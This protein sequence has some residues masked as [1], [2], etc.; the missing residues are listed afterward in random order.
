[1]L[2]ATM[3][4]QRAGL[5][6]VGAQLHGALGDVG[7]EQQLS[8]RLWKAGSLQGVRQDLRKSHAF[9]KMISPLGGTAGQS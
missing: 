3:T 7:S 6:G 9:I 4:M 5:W 2:R 1:M 8:L